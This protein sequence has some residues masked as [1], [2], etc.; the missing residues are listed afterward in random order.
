MSKA[1]RPKVYTYHTSHS[2]KDK[3]GNE[4]RFVTQLYAVGIYGILNGDPAMQGTYTPSQIVN[5]EKKQREA[6]QRLEITDLQFGR[7]IKVT[8]AS[9]LWEEVT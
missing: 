5:I 6:V 3:E 8:D 2:F 4:H 7:K 9:G 1:K